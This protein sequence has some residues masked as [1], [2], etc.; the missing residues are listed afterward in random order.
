M[1]RIIKAVP[2]AI[3]FAKKG[4]YYRA[5][6]SPGSSTGYVPTINRIYSQVMCFGEDI[7]IDRL[8][9]YVYTAATTGGVARMGLYADDGTLHPGQ[10]IY[11]SG[12]IDTTTTGLKTAAPPSPIVIAKG[13]PFWTCFLCGAAAPKLKSSNANCLSALGAGNTIGSWSFNGVYAN[14]AYGALPATHP[15]GMLLRGM[16]DYVHIKLV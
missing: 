7:A 4:S 14:R 16:Y 10:L 3:P 6:N 5:G 1:K 9:I 8:A 15:A 2:F 11:D 13:T 12:E